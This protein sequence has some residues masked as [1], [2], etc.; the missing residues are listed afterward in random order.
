MWNGSASV[1]IGFA[2]SGADGL[3]YAR[4]GNTNW[5]TYSDPIDGDL[6][7]NITL[8]RLG[9]YDGSAWGNRLL[10]EDIAAEIDGGAAAAP[11]TTLTVFQMHAPNCV[12]TNY[13]QD[14]NDR[15]VQLPTAEDQLSCLFD[16][17]TA[18]SN[19][20]GA[21][22]GVSD[23]IYLIAADGTIAAGSDNGYARM[24]A[25]QVGQSFACW[26]FKAESAAWDWKCKA[27]AIGTSTFA[28]N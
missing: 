28:A 20:W 27:I 12:V 6:G 19:K 2:F 14:A 23:K 13:G 7:Y 1:Q 25:A 8:G 15:Y 4:F 9:L 5:P 11:A 17:G 3:N 24:T 22:A 10:A 16:V 26:S 18:R 21:R